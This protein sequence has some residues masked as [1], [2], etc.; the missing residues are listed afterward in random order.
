MSGKRHPRTIMRLWLAGLIALLVIA[1]SA[2]WFADIAMAHDCSGPQDCEQTAGYNAVVSVVGAVSAVVAG[3]LG[4]TIA[5]SSG[6]TAGAITGAV[7]EGVEEDPGAYGD[8]AIED[9]EIDLEVVGKPGEDSGEV[10]PDEGE[11]VVEDTDGNKHYFGTKEDADRYHQKLLDE[12][13]AEMEAERVTQLENDY[14]S[15]AEQVGFL[16]SIIRGLKNAGKDA[17]EQIRERDRYIRE[18]DSLRN[19][20]D[21]AGGNSDY[22]VRERGDWQFGENDAFM[23]AQKDRTQ[24]LDTIHQMSNAVDRMRDKGM[25]GENSALTS[26]ILDRLDKMS[27]DMFRDGAKEPSWEDIQK[28][29]DIIRQDM[30]ATQSRQ[31]ANDSSWFRDGAL[32]SSR[33]IF[34]GVDSEGN[35]SYKAMVLRGL[36]AAASSG[37]SEMAM[38]VMEKMY[39]VHDDVM[40]GKSGTEAFTNAVKRVITDEITGRVVEG[41]LHAGGK[42]GSEVYEK[43]V[44]GSD[45]DKSLTKITRN[46][47]DALHTDVGDLMRGKGDD[48]GDSLHTRTG[49]GI[50]EKNASNAGRSVE[51]RSADFETGRINGEA[52]VKDLEDAIEYRRNNPD[53]PDADARIKSAVDAVQQDKHAMHQLNSRGGSSNPSETISEFNKELKTSYEQAHDTTRQRI[54]DEY[55]VPI[56]DVQVVKPT[57]T[58][59]GGKIDPADPRGFANRP[60]GSVHTDPGDYAQKTPDGISGSGEKASFDQD[61]TYRVKQNNVIDPHTGKP[62]VDPVTGE[63][64]SGFVDVRKADTERIYNQEFYKSRHGGDLPTKVDPA[65]GKVEVDMDQVNKYAKDM[66]QACTD[67]LD[68]E[69]YGNGDRDLQT[70][71]QGDY[72]GRA[73]DDVEGVGKTMEHKN[74]EWQNQAAETRTQA[75]EADARADAF[76]AS[77]DLDGAAKARAEANQLHAKAEGQ[78]EEGYR[79]TT[80]QFHNQI[81][82]RVDALNNQ[83]GRTV[84][85]VPPRLEQAVKIMENPN[86]S[87]A[88]IDAELAKINYTPNKVVQ[89]MSSNLEALQKFKPPPGFDYGEALSDAAV[90]AAKSGPGMGG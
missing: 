22:Q 87:P 33:E 64:T 57:N 44:K 59:P 65:T 77:G 75:L 50:P 90:G 31:A 89:Q 15:A 45:L 79:Q 43:V 8:E 66:D 9:Q 83:Y 11:W 60:E 85:E 54:A 4:A 21:A 81:E 2:L 7:I 82:A 25:V 38:E 32:D 26:K 55:G 46:V 37:K 18:R 61:V 47:N 52:K 10:P 88:Q 71:V 30:D 13:E 17:S 6:A 63:P 12:Y 36:L 1:G 16:D 28:L 58:P 53:A 51:Q 27:D 42:V 74:Y 69:A 49:S 19:K 80:K 73:F 34:T 78:I 67:R 14:K 24:R 41:G 76:E 23:D 86:L 48:I 35:T 70:A 20:V 39:G 62:H 72:K 84:A 40:A 3:V 5:S 68:A 29:K 56:E